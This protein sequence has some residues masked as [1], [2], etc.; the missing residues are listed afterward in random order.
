MWVW[1]SAILWSFLRRQRWTCCQSPL[2]SHPIL[3]ITFIFIL[4][5]LLRVSAQFSVPL[6]PL[7]SSHPQF[8][9]SMTTWGVTTCPHPPPKTLKRRT[10]LN[11]R[12]HRAIEGLCEFVLLFCFCPLK[13]SCD[14]T[15]WKETPLISLYNCV[16]ALLLWFMFSTVNKAL[17]FPEITEQSC[18]L[19]ALSQASHRKS[20]GFSAVSQLFSERWPST[21]AN[22][23]FS[24]PA[25]ER[26]IDFELDVRVEIDSG[27]CVLHPTTQQ[28]EHEDI[29]FRRYDEMHFIH[30]ENYR[31]KSKI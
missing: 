20:S 10:S 11:A 18:L 27:K 4:H 2:T 31:K 21:P 17:Q 29:S 14:N 16:K 6:A 3:I 30:P 22:R 26:N 23:S 1:L 7:L 24:G 25:T 5:P 13:H 12:D 28:P 15:R 19:L 8:P 9:S